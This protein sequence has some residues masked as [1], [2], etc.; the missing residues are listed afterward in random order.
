M[1]MSLSL[2]GWLHAPNKKALKT[3]RI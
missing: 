3:K 1:I 2:T